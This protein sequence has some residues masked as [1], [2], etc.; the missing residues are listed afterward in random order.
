MANY[1]ITHTNGKVYASLGEG[2]LD[3]RLG[4]S[5]LGQNFHN[6]GQLIADNFLHLLEH[7][8]SD[9]QPANPVAGQIW[10][11]T[12]THVLSF[13]DGDRFK[14]CSSSAVGHAPP[15]RPLDG[16]QWWDTVNNQLR[17]YDGLE[18][19]TIGPVYTKGQLFSGLLPT[20]VIDS[21]SYG[22][23]VLELQING[24]TIATVSQDPTFT[25]SLPLNGITQVSPGLTL[26]PNTILS[27]TSL[28]SQQLGGTAA[29]YFVT[30]NALLNV[31][32]GAL[33]I[34]GPGGILVSGLNIASD[35]F[36]DYHIVNATRAVSL[37]SGGS[38]I[39]VNSSGTATC[40]VAPTVASSI[41][42]KSYVDT[43]I[44]S[45]G[46]NGNSYVD[47]KIAALVNGSPIPT[48]N[49]LSDAINNDIYFAVNTSAA[50]EFKAN[51]ASPV[52]TGSPV[53]ATP[54]S[55]DSSGRLATTAFVK[56]L[57]AGTS[58]SGGTTVAGPI[59]PTTD[60]TIDIGSAAARFRN[61]YGR[62]MSANYADLA[63]NY[64]AD[65]AY[66]PGTVVVFGGDEEV[67]VSDQYC[68]HRVAGIVSTDPAYLMN[69]QVQGVAVALTG[70]VPCSV[71]G[72][73]KKGDLLVNSYQ[74]GVAISIAQQENW[75]PGCV[76][77]KSLETD[78]STGIRN[79]MVAVGRF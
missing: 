21:A 42:T 47:A 20:T 57:L 19:V 4:I 44:V 40:S 1:V 77:G 11:N 37:S 8:A 48:L 38:S 32:D 71:L 72:P 55:S 10:W 45:A 73:V 65:A 74:A 2:V 31:L 27:G 3:N 67:T 50:L 12:A 75:K 60:N 35:S 78:H 18:W 51:L 22:H 28:N 79:I 62:A 66:L 49:G 30:K 58:G 39:T 68:D 29:E 61:I 9:A 5:L 34:N 63:E 43:A 46:S 69:G 36:G 7:Q 56:N 59:L 54:P 6:Y 52:F 33:T 16:D 15:H 76:I 70:K 13:F 64:V 14:P 24:N 17:I 26:S 25:L 53:A 41:T 23:L